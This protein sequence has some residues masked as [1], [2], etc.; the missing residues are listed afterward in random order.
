[1]SYKNQYHNIKVTY[2]IQHRNG[3][4]ILLRKY[5]GIDDIKVTDDGETA[6]AYVRIRNKNIQPLWRNI[7]NLTLFG[8]NIELHYY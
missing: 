3:A 5:V 6:T 1:M 4:Y 8:I 7:Q 2:P